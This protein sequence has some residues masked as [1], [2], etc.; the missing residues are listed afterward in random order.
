MD[1]ISGQVTLAR[2][3]GIALG[4]GILAL[5]WDPFP[6][7]NGWMRIVFGVLGLLWIARACFLRIAVDESNVL[8]RDWFRTVVIP[9]ESIRYVSTAAYDGLI[10]RGTRSRSLTFVEFR[11][12]DRSVLVDATVSFRGFTRRKRDSLRHV[13]ES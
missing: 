10:Q 5:A 11:C 3:T 1:S 13:L 12:T 7:G 8:V 2:W 9:R 6:R 4:A